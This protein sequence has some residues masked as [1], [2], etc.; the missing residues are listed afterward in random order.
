MLGPD[1][2]Q[3]VGINSDTI[4]LYAF[5]C[6]FDFCKIFFRYIC[7]IGQSDGIIRNRIYTCNSTYDFKKSSHCLCFAGQRT[8]NIKIESKH[9]LYDIYN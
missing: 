8:D 4:C 1:N 2:L 7:L 3:L 5:N 6:F 9:R